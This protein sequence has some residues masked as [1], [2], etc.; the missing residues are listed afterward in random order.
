[1][2]RAVIISHGRRFV[3]SFLEKVK[4]WF[5]VVKRYDPKGR[6]INKDMVAMCPEASERSRR[7]SGEASGCG[8]D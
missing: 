8:G 2:Q 5:C 4:N 7:R 3:K 1:M 6:K